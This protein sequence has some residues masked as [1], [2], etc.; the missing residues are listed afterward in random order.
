MDPSFIYPYKDYDLIEDMT[1]AGKARMFSFGGLAKTKDGRIILPSKEGQDYVR[2]IHQLTHLGNE[3]LKQLIKEP[4]IAWWA[5]GTGLTPCLH[6]SLFNSTRD[7]CILV[8][9]VPRVIYHDD[10]SFIDE[11]DHRTRYKREPVTLPLAVLLGLGVAAGV[12]TGVAALVQ[13]PSY[14]NEPRAAVD[15]DLGALEQSITKLEESLTSLSE[16]V[17]QNRR[18]LDLLFLKEGGLCAALKEECC[19]YV[20][21][22]GVIRDSMT[23][24]RKR[25]ESRSL[26]RS[27]GCHQGLHDKA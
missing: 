13:Q 27:F 15:A 4:R 20:D 26:C 23:K 25:L 19:F 3:K 8:Q 21:H 6:T 1:G 17:L 9:L 18:G 24:L 16:V 10:S 11:F 7:F 2:Q 14:Y 12:G 22:S 5:C